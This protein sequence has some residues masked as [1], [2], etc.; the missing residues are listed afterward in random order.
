MKVTG[1]SYSGG[2]LNEDAERLALLHIL[3]WEPK[4]ILFKRGSETDVVPSE[5]VDPTLSFK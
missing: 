5:V 1:N 3:R 2:G 4:F